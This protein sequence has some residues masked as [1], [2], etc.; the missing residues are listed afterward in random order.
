MLSIKA[1]AKINLYLDVIS[2]YPDGYHQIESVMQSV[3]LH[4]LVQ[5]FLPENNSYDLNLSCTK[6]EL[7]TE[8]NLAMKAAKLLRKV[9][10]INAGAQIVIEKRIPVAA[11]LA[12]GSAD[13]AATLAGL[14]R[15]WGLNLSLAKLQQ[16]GIILGADVPFCLSGGTQFAEG[17][18]EI[19][20]PLDTTPKFSLV[21]ATPPLKVSTAEIYR[22]IDEDIEA[23]L[24][25]S[26]KYL[27]ALKSGELGRI[28]QA[29]ENLLEIVAMKRY[30]AVSK[31]KELLLKA[32]ALGAMMSGSGPSVFAICQ[33]KAQASQVADEVRRA[34]PD[35]FI[36]VTEPVS[37]GIEII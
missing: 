30:P 14:N 25:K 16:I 9:T 4:D 26:E 6:E 5:V 20:T 32:G 10:G 8:D 18:G 15:L 31:I 37:S 27:Q 29:Q 23:P 2:R 19:L 3:S 33:S 7:A 24:N 36:E 34:E 21:I 1:Y 11:G 13:A 28:V 35:T 22:A 17:R 12:G